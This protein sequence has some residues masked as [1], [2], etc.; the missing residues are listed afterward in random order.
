[1]TNSQLTK[2]QIEQLNSIVKAVAAT[3]PVPTPAA[4]AEV[5]AQIKAQFPN[6]IS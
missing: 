4:I 5:A 2:Q 1:M 3:N 6:L